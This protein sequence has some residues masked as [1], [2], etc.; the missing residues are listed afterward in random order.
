MVFLKTRPFVKRNNAEFTNVSNFTSLLMGS[1]HFTLSCRILLFSLP[2]TK[3][4]FKFVYSEITG[5][6]LNG[7]CLGPLAVVCFSGI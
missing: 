3:E 1:T 4:F 2:T 5:E 6:L 7:S